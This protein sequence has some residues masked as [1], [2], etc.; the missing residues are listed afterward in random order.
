[1]VGTAVLGQLFDRF[2]W[3]ACVSGIAVALTVAALLAYQLKISS[4]AM[5]ERHGLARS[6]SGAESQ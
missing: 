6:G 1:L 4:V 3:E 5:D 2:G